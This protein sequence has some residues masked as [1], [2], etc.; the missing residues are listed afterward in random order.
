[1]NLTA[2]APAPAAA[3]S[4]KPHLELDF[5]ATQFRSVTDIA[6]PVRG[7]FDAP[8]A[9][10]ASV[11]GNITDLIAEATA[12][13]GTSATFGEPVAQAIEGAKTRVSFDGVLSG[14]TFG[15]GATVGAVLAQLAGPFE[16]QVTAAG[17]FPS[18]GT[19]TLSH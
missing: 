9:T 12:L 10:V 2:T 18:R 7:T 13:A 6:L 15:V 4:A 17:P 14:T 1:M 19:V 3:P 5:G 11:L 16:V 8:T